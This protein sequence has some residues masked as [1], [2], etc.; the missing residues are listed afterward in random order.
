MLRL[1][2]ERKAID[3]EEQKFHRENARVLVKLATEEAIQKKTKDRMDAEEKVA[4]ARITDALKTDNKKHEYL[5]YIDYLE[6]R[7]TNGGQETKWPD[8]I[9][10]TGTL[11]MSLDLSGVTK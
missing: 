7:K 2:Q 8:E 3:K 10:K 9:G 4:L 1:S 5:S 11:N 6:K